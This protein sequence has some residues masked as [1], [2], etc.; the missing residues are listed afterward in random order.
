MTGAHRFSFHKKFRT[1]FLKFQVVKWMYLC[2]ESGEDYIR[3][4][5]SIPDF[6]WHRGKKLLK[7]HYLKNYIFLG[8]NSSSPTLCYGAPKCRQCLISKY[9]GAQILFAEN[10]V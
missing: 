10:C 4:E 1:E 9:L 6:K 3:C 8:S 5:K 2:G 7:F